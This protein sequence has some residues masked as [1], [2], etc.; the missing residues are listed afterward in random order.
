MSS[1][2][3][4]ELFANRDFDP[5]GTTTGVPKKRGE[6]WPPLNG[7]GRTA[8]LEATPWSTFGVLTDFASTGSGRMN[9]A[10]FAA[11]AIA[12]A[13]RVN[14]RDSCVGVEVGVSPPMCDI[15]L[16]GERGVDEGEG[17]DEHRVLPLP[18]RTSPSR[19]EW[20]ESIEIIELER[21]E[22]ASPLAP[23]PPVLPSERDM[24]DIVEG[25]GSWR[26]LVAPGKAGTWPSRREDMDAIDGDRERA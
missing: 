4:E 2:D 19:R 9:R 7:E 10:G 26:P 12:T 17:A 13:P 21:R 5:D 24:I 22:F 1:S 18:L 3:G 11:A 16:E 25:D 8:A 15:D 14:I 23:L 20:C 6:S